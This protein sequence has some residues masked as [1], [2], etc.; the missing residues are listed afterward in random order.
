MRNKSKSN[1]VCSHLATTAV[2]VDMD[3][4]LGILDV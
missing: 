2:T 1:L 3:K 4:S